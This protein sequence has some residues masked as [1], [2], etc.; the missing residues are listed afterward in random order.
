M[1][2]SA[3]KEAFLHALE[4]EMELRTAY[5]GQ[6]VPKTLYIGGGTPSFLSAPEL[7]RIVA[8][9]HRHYPLPAGA[10]ST[11][12]ANPEDLTPANLRAWNA[13]GF[14]RLSIGIQ[15]LDDAVLKRVG[16]SHSAAQALI[17]LERVAAAGYENVS[18]DLMLG[19]P[20]STPAQTLAD[21]ELLSHFPLS[22]ISVYML[23]VDPGSV[24]ERQQAAGKLT[25]PAE[26]ETVSLF[27]TVSEQLKQ[28]G[29]EHYEISNFARHRAYSRH[30]SRY[31]QQKPYLGLGPSAHSYDGTSRQWNISRIETYIASLDKGILPFEREELTL[32]DKYNEYVM[33]SLR[34]M[35]GAEWDLLRKPPGPAASDPEKQLMS[36]IENGWARMEAGRFI[37]TETGWLFSDR[38]F[39][40]LFV[41]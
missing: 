40:E 6:T 33:T 19:L 4:K 16:R 28:Q 20:G 21:L 23:G 1:A 22:H 27:L 12:E 41:V 37:L 25:L 34:T 32:S 30:N 10:E 15:T 38:I 3:R 18:V 26:Q 14:N 5:L 8:G 2:S 35:W 24:F 13:C 17:G 39:S 7:E 31:W 11:L 36:Y 29:F 9:L